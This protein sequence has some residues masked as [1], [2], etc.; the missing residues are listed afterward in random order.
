MFFQWALCIYA[1]E[2]RTKLK[3]W[4]LIKSSK[5]NRNYC[6]NTCSLTELLHWRAVLPWTP[7]L[8]HCLVHKPCIQLAVVLAVSLWILLHLNGGN[9]YLPCSQEKPEKKGFRIIQRLDQTDFQWWA[10]I[11]GFLSKRETN[12]FK[13]CERKN[14]KKNKQT[15]ELVAFPSS[16]LSGWW[17]YW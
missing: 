10:T 2:L 5:N 8:E 1:E 3:L 12:I 14:W 16:C 17:W 4:K 11:A 6:D 9:K 15:C 13:V 7:R